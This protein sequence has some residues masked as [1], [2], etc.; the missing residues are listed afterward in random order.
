MEFTQNTVVSHPDVVLKFDT[1]IDC[2]S[3][4]ERGMVEMRVNE[5]TDPLSSYNYWNPETQQWEW[6]NSPIWRMVALYSA[7]KCEWNTITIS[8]RNKV[9][10]GDKVRFRF[11]FKAGGDP[12]DGH[13]GWLIGNIKLLGPGSPEKPTGFVATQIDETSPYV[14]SWTDN[15]STETRF[16]IRKINPGVAGAGDLIGETGSNVTRFDLQQRTVDPNLRVR[17]C[18]G[19]LCSSFSV[20]VVIIPPPPRI[21]SITPSV[22]RSVGGELLTINGA[23]FLPGAVVRLG[24]QICTSVTLVSSHEIRCRTPS[25]LESHLYVRVRNSDGQSTVANPAS[26]IRVVAPKWLSTRGGACSSVC[27][28]VGLSSKPSPEG[29]YCTS[30]ELIPASAVGKV[31]YSNGCWPNRN[32]RAQGVRAG[33]SVGQFCYGAAQRRDRSKSDITMGCFC[34][35]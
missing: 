1:K 7:A 15:G 30:G 26:V 24:T 5:E 8:L 28:S 21:T 19:N 12:S 33:T 35:L 6:L 18:N 2:E 16:E 22:I 9:K 31:T 10:E 29:S 34:D 3:V 32:C 27:G 20:P 4:Y 23:G 11:W 17:A 14:L 13:E 25:N